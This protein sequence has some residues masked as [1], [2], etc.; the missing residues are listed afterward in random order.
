MT[1]IC[2]ISQHIDGEY[3]HK[4]Y[5]V[6]KCIECGW[7]RE[8]MT[9]QIGMFSMTSPNRCLKT[10]LKNGGIRTIRNIDILP[11][12]CPLEEQCQN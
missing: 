10:R 3:V 8:P 1:K 9:T 2:P 7:R 6:N 4:V 12:W 5:D 11:S